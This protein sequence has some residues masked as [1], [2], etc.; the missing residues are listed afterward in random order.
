MNAMHLTDPVLREALTTI[1]RDECQTPQKHTRMRGLLTAI[2]TE[3]A[4]LRAERDAKSSPD[5]KRG[6]R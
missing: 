2:D 1:L 4:T 5:E 3:L 6:R